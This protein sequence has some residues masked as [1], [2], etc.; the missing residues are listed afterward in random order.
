MHKIKEQSLIMK[1]CLLKG[2]LKMFAEIMNSSWEA[3]KATS[4]S[5]TNPRLEEIYSSAIG[6]G[7]ISGKLS[8]AG[9]GGF[10]LFYVSPEKRSSLLRCLNQFEGN[11]YDFHF[12]QEGCQSWFF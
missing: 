12:T 2:D 9:G 4:K 5:V 3:K 8:G 10:F 11:T 7:A 6:A 1:E